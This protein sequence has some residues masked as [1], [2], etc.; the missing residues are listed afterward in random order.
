MRDDNKTFK[1]KTIELG[2][3]HYVVKHKTPS[4]LNNKYFIIL[5]LIKYKY[6]KFHNKKFV[7]LMIFLGFQ[8]VDDFYA[9]LGIM[10]F[11]YLVLAWLFVVISSSG[12]QNKQIN[13]CIK[14]QCSIIATHCVD[15]DSHQQRLCIR[16]HITILE[17]IKKQYYIFNEWFIYIILRAGLATGVIFA[18]YFLIFAFCKKISSQVVKFNDQI[19]EIEEV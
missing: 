15:K 16:E 5:G 2:G 18:L 12:E 7:P 8:T 9:F 4:S 3:K 14:N 13:L 10:C 6:N 19:P 17:I 11:M 1:S